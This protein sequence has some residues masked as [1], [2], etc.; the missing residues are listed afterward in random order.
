MIDDE[1]RNFAS[2][3]LALGPQPDIVECFALWS[4]AGGF[5]TAFAEENRELV[6]DVD[7]FGKAC[8]VLY[9]DS[10]LIQAARAAI[11]I[12]DDI[13]RLLPADD[14]ATMTKVLRP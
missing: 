3:F 11:A 14:V 6:S 5:V 7:Q 1:Q 9:P 12:A 13:A 2:L 10:P 4:L 8:L